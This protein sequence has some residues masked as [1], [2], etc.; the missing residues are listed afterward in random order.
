MTTPREV[1]LRKQLTRLRTMEILSRIPP[2]CCPTK[3]RIPLSKAEQVNVKFGVVVQPANR[4]EI[5]PDPV[6]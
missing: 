4:K 1:T 6:I 3:R 5:I 2:D